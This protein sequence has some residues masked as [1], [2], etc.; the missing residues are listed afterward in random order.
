MTA[1]PYPFTP[2]SY[3]Y[4]LK[5]TV[6]DLLSAS[7]GTLLWVM[8]NPSTA[9]D[10]LDDPTIRKCIGFTRRWGFRDLSVVNL[11]AMRATKP[12]DLWAAEAQGLDVIGP[13]NDST[14]VAEALTAEKV[15]CAWGV[16]PKAA[17]ARRGRVLDLLR[18]ARIEA[19]VQLLMISPNGDG[20]P[21]HPLMAKYTEAPHV[22][23]H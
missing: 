14:I 22:W 11:Y 19:P 13:E 6:T 20:S 3:R 17:R 4:T 8:L 18:R 5:R 23:S 15:V 10:Q 21:Q 16:L 7:R 2:L 9:D 1:P 12:V